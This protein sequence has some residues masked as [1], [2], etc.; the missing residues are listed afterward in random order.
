MGIG[1]VLEQIRATATAERHKGDLFE[2]LV[3]SALRLDRTYAERFA[4]VWLWE[5]WPDRPG[6]DLGIDLVARTPGGDLV[7]TCTFHAPDHTVLKEDI[8][9]SFTEGGRQHLIDGALRGFSERIIVA[10]ATTGRPTPRC[11]WT[12]RRSR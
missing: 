6:V 2:R 10:P 8:D 11:P 4:D 5:E 9:S 1:A 3:R 7:A 12:T